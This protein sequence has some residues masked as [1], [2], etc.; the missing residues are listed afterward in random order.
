MATATLTTMFYNFWGENSCLPQ[1]AT[2]PL[3]AAFEDPSCCFCQKQTKPHIF[4][5]LSTTHC[6]KDNDTTDRLYQRW[7]NVQIL[8]IYLCYFLGCANFLAV[9]IRAN[10]LKHCAKKQYAKTTVLLAL[11]YWD[12]AIS[13]VLLALCY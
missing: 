7:K 12:C 9:C 11:C 8:Q 6:L 2:I 10:K 1:A 3:G 13:T 5:H 4:E